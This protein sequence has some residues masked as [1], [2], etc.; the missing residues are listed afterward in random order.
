MR[1]FTLRTSWKRPATLRT[2]MARPVVRRV[3]RG[4]IG[5]AAKGV[6]M[7][8]AKAVD[9]G[10]AMG[11]TGIVGAARQCRRVGRRVRWRNIEVPRRA[12]MLRLRMR[13]WM[14]RLGRLRRMRLV[15]VLQALMVDADGVGVADGGGDVGLRVR[16]R[17]RLQLRRVLGRRLV[18]MRMSLVLRLRRLAKR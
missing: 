3:L 13:C 4:A 12:A 10:G 16:R 2:L 6:G 9:A 11:A 17:A 8:A 7:G 1:S 5:L 15:R 18:A 14:W